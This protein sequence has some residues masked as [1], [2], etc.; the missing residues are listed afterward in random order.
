MTV[1]RFRVFVNTTVTVSPGPTWMLPGSLPSE[2]TALAK[3]Q[4][5]G[6]V[7]ATEYVPGRSGPELLV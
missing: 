5:A 3:V 4:P 1:P 2:Q 7:S 6:K